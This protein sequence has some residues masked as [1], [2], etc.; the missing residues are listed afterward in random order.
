MNGIILSMGSVCTSIFTT[1]TPFDTE[2]L[3]SLLMW[4]RV[5]NWNHMI[6]NKSKENVLLVSNKRIG[7]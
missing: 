3:C 6:T 7:I 1:T 5:E 2:K 4:E